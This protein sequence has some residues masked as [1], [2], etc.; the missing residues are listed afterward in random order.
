MKVLLD[1]NIP[2]ALRSHFPDEC[3]V[4]TAQY[5]GWQDYEDDRLLSTAIEHGFSLLVTLDTNLKDQQPLGHWSIGVIIFDIHPATPPHFV[6][7]MQDIRSVLFDV[8]ENEAL[9]EV[10]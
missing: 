7:R 2:H 8:A 3:E 10:S 6:R 4:Y 9:F 1:H 5:L